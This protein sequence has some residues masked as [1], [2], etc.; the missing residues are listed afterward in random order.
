MKQ[1]VFTGSACAIIT[2]FDENRKIDYKALRRQ[3]DFQISNGT[4]AIV[5]CG[6][7][8]ECPVLDTREH[9]QMIKTTVKY[10]DGRVPVIAGTG[11][12]STVTAVRRS[13]AAYDAG[14]DALLIVTP[15]YNK[16]SQAGLVEHYAYI[17]DRVNM[18]II[19]YNVPTRTGVNILPETYLE[20]SRI[21]HVVAAKE[22]NGDISALA[23]T[24][25]LCGDELDIYCGND[26]QSA[27]FAAMGSKGTISVLANIM[28][29][30]AHDIVSA[31]F[32]GNFDLSM[33]LQLKYLRMCNELFC[34]VN[35]MPVKYAMHELKMDSGVCRLPLTELSEKNKARMLN[36]LARYELI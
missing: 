18:P 6:T 31:A 1:T 16:C 12:N 2:P 30:E 24:I 36:A 17:S 22:S 33:K 25:N 29:R 15:Y 23:K 11:S 19:V 10:V 5:V 35:P 13:I 20:L 32:E 8:G 21:N 27:S 4:D 34:D 9:K 28:P 26:D 7:T 3:I 14:A